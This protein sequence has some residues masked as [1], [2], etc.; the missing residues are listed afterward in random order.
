MIYC[1]FNKWASDDCASDLWVS[2]YRHILAWSTCRCFLRVPKQ[3]K[4]YLK[5]SL[6]L[7]ALLPT[8]L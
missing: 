3:L 7:L 1:M 2:D 6:V 4:V 8:L 5:N